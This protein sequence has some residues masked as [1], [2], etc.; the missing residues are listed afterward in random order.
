MTLIPR[1]L[2]VALFTSPFAGHALAADLENGKTLAYTCT[3]CHGVPQ[4]RNA[5]PNYYVPKIAGQSEQY[6]VNALKA[7]KSGDR[8]HPTM[9]AQA[10]SFSDEDIADIAAYIATTK[11]AD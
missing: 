11:A 6:L 10:S 4:Y 8:K 5:Y 7:Y 3:G 1:L 9:N 2:A